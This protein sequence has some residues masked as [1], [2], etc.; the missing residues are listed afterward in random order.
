MPIYTVKFPLEVVSGRETFKVLD[1]SNI[2]EVVKFNLKS[3]I[4]TCPGE[5]RSNPDFGVCAKGYLFDFAGNTQ[6]LRSK[7]FRQVQEYVPYC[8][9]DN[10]TVSTPEDDPNSIYIRIQYTISEINK[11]DVFELILST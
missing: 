3:T 8:F 4:L 9:I 5:R 2:E 7:I 6:E 10:L 1:D 11:R